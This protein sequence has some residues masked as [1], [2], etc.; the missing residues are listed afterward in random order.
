MYNKIVSLSLLTAALLASNSASAALAGTE[1]DAVIA[2]V[3]VG[4]GMAVAAVIAVAG[5]K[6]IKRVF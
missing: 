5:F 1:M 3:A 4:G 2:D 6:Y